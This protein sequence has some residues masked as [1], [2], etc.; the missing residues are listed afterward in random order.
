LAAAHYGLT[1]HSAAP[2]RCKEQL[3]PRGFA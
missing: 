1:A 3:P 2:R